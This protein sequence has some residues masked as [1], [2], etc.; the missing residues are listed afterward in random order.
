MKAS[1]WI[2]VGLE[3]CSPCSEWPWA[4]ECKIIIYLIR[5]PNKLRTLILCFLECS[6][7]LVCAHTQSYRPHVLYHTARVPGFYFQRTPG[8]FAASSH[9]QGHRENCLS[10]SFYDW[11]AN[12]QLLSC[13]A[14]SVYQCHVPAT[15]CVLDGLSCSGSPENWNMVS[16]AGIRLGLI[17]CQKRVLIQGTEQFL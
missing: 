16:E 17:T 10:L 2:H 1:L 4:P 14:I 13:N 7:P 8:A 12:I 6:L 11:I 5:S 15:L 9:V 3:N